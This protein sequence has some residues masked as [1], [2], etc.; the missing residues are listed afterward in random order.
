MSA[1][2][3]WWDVQPNEVSHLSCQQIG[4]LLEKR[5]VEKVSWLSDWKRIYSTAQSHSRKLQLLYELWQTLQVLNRP[6]DGDEYQNEC[7]DVEFSEKIR[8]EIIEHFRWIE[9][10]KRDYKFVKF[11]MNM[12]LLE[13]G[14]K[15]VMPGVDKPTQDAVDE[16]TDYLKKKKIWNLDDSLVKL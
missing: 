11:L 14:V 8:T 13:D 7:R 10:G 12:L 4:R 2:G 3:T 5:W 6:Y 1:R 15:W 16:A 9:G